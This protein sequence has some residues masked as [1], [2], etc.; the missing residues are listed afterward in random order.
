MFVL[1]KNCSEVQKMF[2]FSFFV[3]IK[4]FTIVKNIR[5]FQI[6][7]GVLKIVHRCKPCVPFSFFMYS[8]NFRI[9]FRYSICSRQHF[10]SKFKIMSHVEKLLFFVGMHVLS[11][12]IIQFY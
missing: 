11:C 9:C 2:L 3:P 5:L 1:F 4:K 7:F 10:L 6:L 12:Y 8:N